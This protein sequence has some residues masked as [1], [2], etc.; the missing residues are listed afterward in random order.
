MNEKTASSSDAG[1]LRFE[2]GAVGGGLRADSPAN[3]D[4]APPR[5]SSS[6]ATASLTPLAFGFSAAELQDAEVM[7]RRKL[8]RDTAAKLGFAERRV[9]L[10]AES[11]DPAAVHTA[12]REFVHRKRVLEGKGANFAHLKQ[13]RAYPEFNKW[14]DQLATFERME[15]AL[16][17]AALAG[18]LRV[19]IRQWLASRAREHHDKDG[20][21]ETADWALLVRDA[22]VFW[23]VEG[24]AEEEALGACRTATGDSQWAPPPPD[25]SAELRAQELSAHE[26]SLREEARRQSLEAAAMSRRNAGILEQSMALQSRE[27]QAL[28]Q[29]SQLAK[30]Q[31]Q[32][33]QLM[34]QAAHANEAAE[35]QRAEAAAPARAAYAQQHYAQQQAQHQAQQ[36]AQHH[37]QQQ[38]SMA[39]SQSQGKNTLWIIAGVIAAL[40]TLGG[41]ALYGLSQTSAGVVR[42]P[43]APGAAPN[44][45]ALVAPQLPTD[46]TSIKERETGSVGARPALAGA[47]RPTANEPLSAPPTAGGTSTSGAPA[48]AATGVATAPIA[49]APP[50]TTATPEPTPTPTP[51][52]TA[53]PPAPATPESAQARPS[54]R[55]SPVVVTPKPGAPRPL[56]TF[57]LPK[58]KN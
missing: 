11:I 33:G 6:T 16:A 48:V 19:E 46:P 27:R 42:S 8:W 31:E 30:L 49:S 17:R 37:A 18:L 12:I 45:G 44:A 1:G 51:A 56:R 2:E 14:Y 20:H 47:E 21:I 58:R 9:E 34:A 5:A 54:S 10:M 57:A 40:L 22:Q 32:A 3:P 36:Q 50:A 53:P 4:E 13:L 25:E 41:G 24:L 29:E 35:R 26:A 55:V 28:A 39:A 38:A 7:M 15:P 52:A 43:A 23:T